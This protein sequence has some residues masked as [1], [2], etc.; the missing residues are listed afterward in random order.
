MTLKSI[1]E[2]LIT[3]ISSSLKSYYIGFFNFFV[4]VLLCFS[5]LHCFLFQLLLFD[6]KK[7]PYCSTNLFD[8]TFCTNLSK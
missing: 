6:F 2:A 4:N 8:I 7:L 1:I 3:S 5:N